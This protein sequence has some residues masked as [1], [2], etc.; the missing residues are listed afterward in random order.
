MN[1]MIFLVM[2]VLAVFA[3]TDILALPVG[4]ATLTWYPPTTNTDA[5]A[6][7]DLAGYKIYYGTASAAYTVTVD[8]PCGILPC[9]GFSTNPPTDLERQQKATSHPT[10]IAISGLED[11]QTWY[12][13]ATAYD[14]WANESGYSNEVSRFIPSAVIN[15]DYDADGKA[16]KAIFRPSEGVWGIVNSSNGSVRWVQWGMS[17]DIPVPADYDND[18]KKDT[19]IFR[20]SSGHWCIIDSSTGFAHCDGP[21]G[22]VGNI[23]VPADYDN[24]GKKDTA[25]FRPSSGHWCI[26][27][28]STG[29]AHCDGPWGTVG[30]I[31]V[32]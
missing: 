27:D 19:A 28:S 17:G 21:W 10:I 13:A 29:F 11:N 2:M 6:L 14:T 3:P 31:P 24:D 1:K 23:P 12:F 9:Q 26:I 7:T 8:I 32:Q 4:T 18:G 25:I 22:T 30:D 15:T 20:P 5:T 16:D